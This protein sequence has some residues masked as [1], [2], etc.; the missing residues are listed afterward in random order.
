MAFAEG[1][2]S[3]GYATGSAARLGQAQVENEGERLRAARQTQIQDR[4]KAALDT[5]EKTSLD[6]YKQYVGLIGEAVQN[7]AT[8]A[9]IK[10]LADAAIKPLQGHALVLGQLRAQATAAG[11]SAEELEL[12]PDPNAFMGNNLGLLQLTVNNALQKTPEAAA[13]RDAAAKLAEAQA[14]ASKLGKPVEEVAQAM[15][16]IPSPPTPMEALDASGKPAFVRPGPDGFQT[17]PGATPIPRRGM[18]IETTPDGGVKVTMGG[19]EEGPGMERPTLARLEKSILDS[20]EGLGRLFEVQRS[21]RPDFLT[22]AGKFENWRLG[23]A[24]KINPAML[25]AQDRQFLGDYTTF[26]TDAVDNMNRYIRDMT[27]AQLSEFEAERLRKGVPDPER[28]GPSVFKAK[29]DTQLRQFALARARAVYARNQGLEKMPFD[30]M[31]LDEMDQLINRRADE[32]TANFAR[33]NI[34]GAEARSRALEQVK[35]EFGL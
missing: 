11:A 29:M 3:R 14:I 1:G 23:T 5:S 15:G 30:A 19:D 34:P 24:E 9:H 35:Q 12:L 22:Y 27:G 26:T 32:L 28:D 33:Q 7:G 21:F 13:A 4:V 6:T 10:Q 18:T 17:V 25:S 31:D 16:L 20:Q 8:E 2:F